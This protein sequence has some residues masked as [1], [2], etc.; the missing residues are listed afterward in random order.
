M[1]NITFKLS[2]EGMGKYADMNCLKLYTIQSKGAILPHE[3]GIIFKLF[4]LAPII[5]AKCATLSNKAAI[6]F[7]L[8]VIC[9]FLKVSL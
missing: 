8:F 4:L 6:R 2:C 3:N 5:G 1:L 7:D 9:L